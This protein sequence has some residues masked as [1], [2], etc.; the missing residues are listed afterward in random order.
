MTTKIKNNIWIIGAI[1][2]VLAISAYLISYGESKQNIESRLF[3]TADQR[4]EVV[5]FVENSLTPV[6]LKIQYILDTINKNHAV[7]IRQQRYDDNKT[8]DS[9][10]STHDSL[11]LDMM[12]RQTV[13]I[14]QLKQELKQE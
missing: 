7:K 6:E 2:T 8:K 4:K 11:F 14:E 9:I 5:D 10:R 12:S 13:Q 1:T 3:E